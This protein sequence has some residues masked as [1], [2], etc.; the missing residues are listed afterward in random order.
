MARYVVVGPGAVGA[1]FAAALSERADVVV[2]AR[3]RALTHLSTH[4]LRFVT[5]GGTRSVTL[6]A[7][8]VDE[9]KLRIDDVLIAAVK[10]QHVAAVAETLAWLP[11][12][13]GDTEVG[14]AAELLSLVT[15]QNGIDAEQT[16]ARWFPH[17]VGA[18]M[19]IAARYT[20]VGEVRVG[21]T[22]HL[23]AI[24]AGLP[25][26]QDTVASA[27]LDAL[28]TDLDATGF[29]VRRTDDIA[30]VKGTK[31][32]HNVKNALEVLA[33]DDEAKSLVAE[34]LE[35]ETRSVLDAA[36]HP[37]G[38]KSILVVDPQQRGGDT[39]LGVGPGAQ[40]TWQSFARGADSHEVDHLNGDVARLARLSGAR[41]PVNTAL[42]IIVGIAARRGGGV[43]LPGLDRLIDLVAEPTHL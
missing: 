30:R 10:A 3:G 16:A 19:S 21:G 39:A 29:A 32:L 20:D 23:G 41:A 17:I 5:S 6:A 24:I 22:P 36:G 26:G 28:L 11:V 4:P 9:L 40:S 1:S 42:Q 43:N 2:V 12:F 38:D 27:T 34:A 25:F 7:I 35:E 13:D 14:V 37:Y 18:T 8:A 15:A 33:G 31:L